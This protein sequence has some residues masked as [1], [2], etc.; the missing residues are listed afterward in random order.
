MPE[1]SQPLAVGQIW[2]DMDPRGRRRFRILAL[3]GERAVCQTLATGRR[4][5]IRT[6]RFR[7]TA[8]GYHLIEQAPGVA[9][10]PPLL[11]V[12]AA[13][14]SARGYRRLEGA[15]GE[16]GV[17]THPEWDGSCDGLLEAVRD[18]LEREA[19]GAKASC[20]PAV[21]GRTSGPG[22]LLM[23]REEGL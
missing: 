16:G 12:L 9:Q 13:E 21:P 22:G 23:G 1:P 4:T 5:R 7:P 11:E 20:R 2:E 3:E 6:S 8:S 19:G 18:C 15:A 10:G 14:L 17:W